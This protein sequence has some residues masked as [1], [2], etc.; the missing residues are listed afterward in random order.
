MTF[1]VRLSVAILL[2][3]CER[4]CEIANFTMNEIRV[5][6]EN[7]PPIYSCGFHGASIK[8]SFQLQNIPSEWARI[9]LEAVIELKKLGYDKVYLIIDDHPPLGRC[10]SEVLNRLLPQWMDELEATYIGL[11]GSDQNQGQWGIKE[12]HYPLEKMDENQLFK[13]QLHPA[14]WKIEKLEKILRGFVENYNPVDQNIWRFERV[15]NDS[16]VD[17]KYLEKTY[18]IEGEK[19]VYSSFLC[20][21]ELRLRAYVQKRIRKWLKDEKKADLIWQWGFAGFISHYYAGP[22]PLMWA[23]LMNG[24]KPNQNIFWYYWSRGEIVKSLIAKKI[25]KMAIRK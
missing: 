18:R 6:W 19:L 2:S 20:R 10:H 3:S 17:K 11:L 25:A 13:F 14:L 24:G 22:Y 1:E 9:H 5:L 8:T 7:H 15:G 23:G 12:K 4:Y 16:W 21:L